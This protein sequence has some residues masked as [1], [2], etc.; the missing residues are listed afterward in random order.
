MTKPEADADLS[1]KCSRCDDKSCASQVLNSEELTLLSQ[2]CCEST[3]VRNETILKEGTFTSHIIYLRSGLVKE[4][5]KNERGQEQILQIIKGHAY[6]GLPSLFGDRINQYSYTALTD[7][8]VCF[9]DVN[10]YKQMILEN[11]KFS[12]E[13]LATVSRESL[14]NYHRLVNKQQKQ[15]GGKIADTLLYFANTIF[16]SD[17]FDLPLNRNEISCLIGSSRESVTKQLNDF[18]ADGLI[19]VD[20]KKIQL[21]DIPMLEKISRF[22]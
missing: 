19:R 13:I 2:N 22:G 7:V 15:L 8:K 10:I 11:G 3:F 18:V 12:F 17:Q 20:G 1:L 21:L 14:H 4:Y 5:S 6:L 16:N 9:I